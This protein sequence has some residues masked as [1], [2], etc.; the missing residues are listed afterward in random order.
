MLVSELIQ[1]LCDNPTE[2]ID[3]LT[4]RRASL[5]LERDALERKI[6]NL[7]KVI[8]IAID[9]RARIDRNNEEIGNL[10]DELIGPPITDEGERDLDLS[11]LY[12]LSG[13]RLKDE[14]LD[15]KGY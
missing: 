15:T 8:R 1:M 7:N 14:D 5:C 9:V 11:N 6:I 2:L 3:D 10:H 4:S 12:V 13:T